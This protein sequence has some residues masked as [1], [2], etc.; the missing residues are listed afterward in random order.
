MR[1]S[2]DWVRIGDVLELV[3]RPVTID[4]ISTYTTIGVRSFG[5]GL[6]H[7]EPTKGNNLSKLRWFEVHPNEL[8]VSNIKGW[9]GAIA[10]SAE[11][12]AGC[13]ASNRFLTYRPRGERVDVRYVAHYFLSEPGNAKIRRASPGST[14][15]NLTL[16]IDAFESLEVA[17]PPL[18]EQRRIADQLSNVLGLAGRVSR[19]LERMRQLTAALPASLAQR[20]DL[21]ESTKRARGW[22]RVA[23]GD[24]MHPV[25]D[26][27]TVLADRSYPNV[28]I[29]SFGRGLF[30]K[31]P[32]DG[33]RTSAKTL[34]RIN[35]GQFI[36]SRLF[37]FE[38]AYAAVDDRFDGYFVS[39][40][41]PTFDVDAERLDAR[42]LAAYLR[43]LRI[44]DELARGSKGLGV[45]RQRVHVD[46]ILAYEVWLPPLEVQ[47]EMVQRLGRLAQV[48]SLRAR[49]EER[50]S[51]LVPA[52]LNEAFGQA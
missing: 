22:R 36:Y 20:N 21:S 4:S 17:L 23:L 14:D 28:G 39:S 12:D 1:A 30:E 18:D 35:A 52:A 51:A 50:L 31:P 42:Y 48:G 44:W 46:T 11:A 34:F 45:R 6:F 2:V 41:F 16:G 26:P 10:V 43:S 38:G 29:L 9:E 47:N 25:A 7:Y 8:V 15:R 24:V 27:H 40:E 13:I 49:Q 5:K 37:A 3:R 33:S 32:V 19:R